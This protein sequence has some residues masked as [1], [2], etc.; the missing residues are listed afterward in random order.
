MLQKA[1]IDVVRHV[2]SNDDERWDIILHT[3]MVVATSDVTMC[4]EEWDKVLQG[5]LDD[6]LSS[7]NLCAKIQQ[8]SKSRS[9][10]F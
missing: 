7:T 1:T 8:L 3:T 10:E 2:A 6:A 5:P 9:I 4:C